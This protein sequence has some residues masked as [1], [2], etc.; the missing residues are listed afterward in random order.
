MSDFGNLLRCWADQHD[1]YVEITKNVIKEVIK[2][3]PTVTSFIESKQEI[4]EY[5]LDNLT[6]QERSVILN[7]IRATKAK[8]G[9]SN[10]NK[11]RHVIVDKLQ[12][13]YKNLGLTVFG[14]QFTVL[15]TPS[16]AP[17]E[18]T[19]D[20]IVDVNP[21]I[22][23]TPKRQKKR[24]VAAAVA[25][26]E[27]IDFDDESIDTVSANDESVEDENEP[28]VNAAFLKWVEKMKVTAANKFGLIIDV[29]IVPDD[30]DYPEAPTTDLTMANLQA[31]FAQLTSDT[32]PERAGIKDVAK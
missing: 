17:K 31:R 3:Y 29:S 1:N 24:N 5:F 22:I 16:K 26:S 28:I 7:P 25:D 12:R 15:T 18:T 2:Q 9:D 32:N 10:K 11:E 20:T 6:S 8:K 14:E 13:W 19:P 4:K 23:E 27:S 21:V 30:G